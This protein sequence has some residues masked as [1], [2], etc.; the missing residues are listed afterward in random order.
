MNVSGV[1]LKQAFREWKNERGLLRQEGRLVVVHDELESELGRI[2]VRDGVASAKGHNGIKS[3][4]Q[5]L[6]GFKWWR[7]GVGIGRPQRRDPEVVSK[8]VLG[9]MSGSQRKA[10]EDSTVHVFKALEDI[11][12]GKR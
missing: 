1:A 2:T 12:E 8:Y 3:C 10:L 5:Q 9:K 4:Q 7:V 11:A 6:G